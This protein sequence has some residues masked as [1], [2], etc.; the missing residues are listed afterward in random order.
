MYKYQLNNYFNF[1][2]NLTLDIINTIV[3]KNQ[4][5]TPSIYTHL[6]VNKLKE[7]K[8]TNLLD[9]ARE[10]RITFFFVPQKMPFGTYSTSAV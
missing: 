1:T 8:Q 6:F 9:I 3:A 7:K 10:V 4:Q 5:L 2:E